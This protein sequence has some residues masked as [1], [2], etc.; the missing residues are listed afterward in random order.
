MRA[1]RGGSTQLSIGSNGLTTSPPLSWS[2][3]KS[4]RGRAI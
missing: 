3:S 2:L 4:I 1:Y